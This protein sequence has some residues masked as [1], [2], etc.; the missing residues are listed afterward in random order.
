MMTPIEINRIGYTALMDA[1]GFDGMIR[2]L[3]QLEPGQGDYT[4]ER[5]QWIDT[6]SLEDVFRDIEKNRPS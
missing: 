5:R 4:T 1:L 3:R 6:V 2:F